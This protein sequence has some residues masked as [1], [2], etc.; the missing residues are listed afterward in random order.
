MLKFLL[1]STFVN[2]FEIIDSVKPQFPKL[3]KPCHNI[4]SRLL[5]IS[6]ELSNNF[7]YF[8]LSDVNATGY[9]CNQQ[10]D[11][12]GYT[13]ISQ[14]SIKQ[15]TNV[16]ISDKLLDIHNTLYNVV[17]HEVLHSM[18]LNHTNEQ[19]MMNYYIHVKYNWYGGIDAIDDDMKLWVSPDDMNGLIFLS[20]YSVRKF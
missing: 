11:N 10:S 2:S 13:S 16:W 5:T 20:N 6:N 8:K 17:L 7:P 4:D 18:G 19:G 12:F 14:D 9:I 3:L 1:Y 15:H